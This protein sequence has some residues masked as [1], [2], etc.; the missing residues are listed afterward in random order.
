MGSTQKKHAQKRRHIR[1]S[2][3]TKLLILTLLVAIGWQLHNLH[4]QVESA[5][6]RK[7]LLAAQVEA[8]T[9]EN[10][11]LAA[12][13]AEGPTPEKMQ[14]IAREELGWVAP[15]EYVFYNRNN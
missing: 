15:G 6:E 2:L 13:I 14:D 11:A 3:P 5:Q 9:Q 4:G 10:D 7:E 12:D 8:K 1:A